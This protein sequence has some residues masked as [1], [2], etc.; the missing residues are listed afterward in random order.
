MRLLLDNFVHHISRDTMFVQLV[1]SG[2]EDDAH[3][4]K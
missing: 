3:L 4:K 2:G 1:S